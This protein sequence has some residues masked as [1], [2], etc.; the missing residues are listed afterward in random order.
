MIK[1][2]ISF[3]SERFLFYFFKCNSVFICLVSNILSNIRFWEVDNSLFYNT[4]RKFFKV[5]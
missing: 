2:L 4:F 5:V 3:L 1:I